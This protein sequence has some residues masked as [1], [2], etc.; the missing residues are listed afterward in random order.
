MRQLIHGPTAHFERITDFV[1]A[2]MGNSGINFC[3]H[4]QRFFGVFVVH[5]ADFVFV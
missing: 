1:T 3:L 2:D 5:L 4:F